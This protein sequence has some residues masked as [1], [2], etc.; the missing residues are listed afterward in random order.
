MKE[1]TTWY[2]LERYISKETGW[3]DE[4]CTYDTY[5]EAIEDLEWNRKLMPQEK[6]RITEE[7]GYV[8]FRS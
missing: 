5:E 4:G 8:I 3:V 7:H 6:W 2:M 1:P